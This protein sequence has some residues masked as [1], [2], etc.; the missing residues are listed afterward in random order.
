[1]FSRLIK[2]KKNRTRKI[3]N[4]EVKLIRKEKSHPTPPSLPTDICVCILFDESYHDHKDKDREREE[5][6]EKR[7]IEKGSEERGEGEK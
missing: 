4:L 1:M 5:K 6:E 3:K 2:I 7:K